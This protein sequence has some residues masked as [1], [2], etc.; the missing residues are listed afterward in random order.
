MPAV[1]PATICLVAMTNSTTSGTV[2][3]TSPANRADQFVWNSP[4][5]WVSPTGNV[6]LLVVRISTSGKKKSAEE[7]GPDEPRERHATGRV[8]EDQANRES[9]MWKL[10]SR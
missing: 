8:D 4:R 6:Y 7:R 1:S 5:N 2:A 10:P 3:I 9:I